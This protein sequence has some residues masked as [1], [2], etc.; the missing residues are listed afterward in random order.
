MARIVISICGEGRGHASRAISLIEKLYPKHQLL[1]LSF[2]D[3][4]RYLHEYIKANTLSIEIHEIAG[5]S[6]QYKGAR[7]A[8]VR[9]YLH[10]AKFIFFRIHFECKRVEVILGSFKPDLSI[11]D[12]EPCVPR[13]SA[14]RGIPCISIDHQHFIRFCTS[15]M[16]P[17]LLRVRAKIGAWVCRLYVP[18]AELYVISAFFN[19]T[20]R[21]PNKKEVVQ[22]GSIIRQE[23]RRQ[24]PSDSGTIISYMRKS[25]P[26]NVMQA[27]L[28]CGHPVIVYGLGK[29]RNHA[30]IEF[31]EISQHEFAAD[32]ARATAVI[33]AAGNQMIG[34]SLYLGKSYFAL[35]ERD[36]HEQVMNSYHL[37]SMGMGSFTYLDSLNTEKLSKFLS[38]KA[39]V[40]AKISRSC[41]TSDAV[42]EIGAIIEDFLGNRSC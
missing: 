20:L 10:W 23:I 12:F 28:N 18:N 32:L 29:A 11:V 35:P 13:V 40:T 15:N 3:G 8:P 2:G 19:S 38:E 9:T 26:S 17:L 34:E 4:Y 42:E 22:V 30:N 5:I 31:K 21:K 6:Y 14:R 24:R 37:Q 41:P 33:G 16:L 27:F 25:I 1:V 36:H 39:R 7:L